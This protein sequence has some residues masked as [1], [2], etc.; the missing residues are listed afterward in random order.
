MRVVELTPARPHLLLV[1]ELARGRR[2]AELYERCIRSV[3]QVEQARVDSATYNPSPLA[4][5]CAPNSA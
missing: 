3:A 1:A 5:A 2:S 4:R